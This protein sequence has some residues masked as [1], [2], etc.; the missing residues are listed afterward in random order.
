MTCEVISL[1]TKTVEGEKKIDVLEVTD[2]DSQANVS[3][4]AFSESGYDLLT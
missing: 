2:A 1:D 3:D 4:C